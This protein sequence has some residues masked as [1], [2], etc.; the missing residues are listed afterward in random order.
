MVTDGTGLRSR[1]LDWSPVTQEAA[2][3]TKLSRPRRMR[4]T[5]PG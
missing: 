3:V 1:S 5:L 4:T 2:P